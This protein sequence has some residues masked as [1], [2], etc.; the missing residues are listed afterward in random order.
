[1]QDIS[2]IGYVAAVAAFSLNINVVCVHS[3]VR[4][5]TVFFELPARQMIRFAKYHFVSTWEDGRALVSNHVPRESIHVVG[6]S[7]FD[8]LGTMLLSSGVTVDRQGSFVRRLTRNRRDWLIVAPMVDIDHLS[9]YLEIFKEVGTFLKD[10]YSIVFW[11]DAG[12]SN[13]FQV[14]HEP[15]NVKHLRNIFGLQTPRLFFLV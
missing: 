9:Y 11:V 5:R 15:K 7:L 8:G 12:K 14:L 1:V 13:K 6:N 4:S 3:P 10:R 2:D